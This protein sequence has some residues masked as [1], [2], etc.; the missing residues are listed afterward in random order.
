[1]FQELIE[2]DFKI[3]DVNRFPNDILKYNIYDDNN[4]LSPIISNDNYVQY[5]MNLPSHDS[6]IELATIDI[7]QSNDHNSINTN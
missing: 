1:M 6:D 5:Y 3:D 2:N 4:S 7:T